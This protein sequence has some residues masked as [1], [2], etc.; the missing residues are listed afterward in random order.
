MSHYYTNKTI[1]STCLFMLESLE[2][3]S[4][5]LCIKLTSILINDIKHSPFNNVA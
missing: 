3:K 5:I 1:K 2:K 4:V